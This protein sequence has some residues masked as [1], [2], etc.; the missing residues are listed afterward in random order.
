[1]VTLALLA[2]LVLFLGG[3]HTLVGVFDAAW[4][5]GTIH[6]PPAENLREFAVLQVFLP[7][8][9][10]WKDPED[11]NNHAAAAEDEL[12]PAVGSKAWLVQQ[13]TAGWR[14]YAARHGYTYHLVGERLGDAGMP[15]HFTRFVAMLELLKTHRC[16]C[17]RYTDLVL[18]HCRV[19]L[20]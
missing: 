8:T 20:H 14:D 15:I 11:A 1:V 12:P 13:S 16:A 9:D 7:L 3:F 6:D 5:A 18:L 10:K 17:R 4:P 2:L 19:L